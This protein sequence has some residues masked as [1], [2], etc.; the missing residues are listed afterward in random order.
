MH[1][2]GFSGAVPG[3][4]SCSATSGNVRE[5]GID[6]LGMS[7]TTVRTNR[8]PMM[9]SVLDLIGSALQFDVSLTCPPR[10]K[11]GKLPD[12]VTSKLPT[13]SPSA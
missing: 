13:A 7:L 1:S 3:G 6:T 5:A 4:G 12:V 8:N 10:F 2:Q 9:I 11:A